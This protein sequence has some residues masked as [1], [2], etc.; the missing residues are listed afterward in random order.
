MAAAPETPVVDADNPRTDPGDWDHAIV[1][2]SYAELR[3]KLA[4]RRTRAT[5]RSA[6]FGFLGVVV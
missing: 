4:E 2:H 3:E 6:E 1:S 5:L